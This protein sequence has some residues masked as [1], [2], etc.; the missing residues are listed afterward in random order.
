MNNRKKQCKFCRRGD[1]T[2]ANVSVDDNG[3]RYQNGHVCLEC[4]MKKINT[5]KLC[6]ECGESLG[7][8]Q[9][10]CLKREGEPAVK[11]SENLARRNYPAC[12][13]A[14]KEI[15]HSSLNVN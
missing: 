4:M 14:E 9:Y 5:S 3:N 10:A 15:Q 13:K 2:V 1:R 6:G 12:K 11:W 7:S 8:L